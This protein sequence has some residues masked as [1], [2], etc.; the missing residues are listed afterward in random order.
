[1]EKYFIK[2]DSTGYSVF[3]Y[4]KDYEGVSTEI[5]GKISFDK[6]SVKDVLE[7]IRGTGLSLQLQADSNLTFEEFSEADE[8]TYTVAVTKNGQMFYKGFLKPDGITQSFVQDLWIVNL[9]FV[10][11]LGVLKDLAFVNSAGNNFVGKLSMFEIIEACLRRTDLEMQINSSVRL[12][13]LG[14]NGTNIL[15]DTYLNADRFFKIDSQTSTG[16]TTMTCEEVL[17][18]VL[19]II[20]ACVTQQDGQW[21]VYRPNEFEQNVVWTNNT[22]DATFTKNLSI[23]LGSQIDNFYPHHCN[24]NQQ[25]ETKGAISAYRIN[26]KYGFKSGILQNSSLNHNGNL[27]FNNWVFNQNM[28]NK[29][30]T[31]VRTGSQTREFD[32]VESFWSAQNIVDANN[33]DFIGLKM[34]NHLK[35]IWYV[36]FSSNIDITTFPYTFLEVLRSNSINIAKDT[37]I[38]FQAKMTSFNGHCFFPFKIKT[39]TNLY[40]Q[41][42]GSWS[43]VNNYFGT[44]AGSK[45]NSDVSNIEF[46][47]KANS[48][49]IDT[50]IEVIIGQPFNDY[51]FGGGVGFAPP[52]EIYAESEITFVNIIDNTNTESGKVGEFHTITRNISPSSITKENQEVYNG[53]SLGDVFEGA[54]YKQDQETL[55]TLWTRN[56]WIEEK[57]ILQIS[58][59][60]DMRISQKTQKVFIGDFYGYIPYLSIVS[61]N[62]LVGKFMFIEHSYD[63]D[64]NIT[65]GK[66][67]QFYTDEVGGLIHELTYDYGQTVKPSIKS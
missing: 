32:F 43:L 55:T 53:D 59:E 8:K 18:S 64:S 7:P 34:R 49:P 19:N 50:T 52:Q 41:P 28:P 48:L 60:D 44:F 56:D 4:E 11:G 6:G 9:D 54:I 67:K 23:S 30:F 66:L 33:T 12:K 45:T 51:Y 31:G 57:S 26:Y 3:I 47:F 35:D 40:L 65:R 24:G 25:I 13:Y 36:P 22:T 58:G 15:K 38:T 39:A 63:T 1:M 20:S 37:I 10:D 27:E 21:W 5:F 16:G 29:L 42:D 46:D 61:I 62:N 17:N 14:Y 2:N